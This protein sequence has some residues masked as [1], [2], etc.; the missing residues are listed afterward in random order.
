MNEHAGRD[1]A[2]QDGAF[3]LVEPHRHGVETSEQAEQPRGGG[4][5][6]GDGDAPRD[7]AWHTRDH[8]RTD[9]EPGGPAGA[10]QGVFAA[11]PRVRRDGDFREVELA[12]FSPDV[13]RLDIVECRPIAIDHRRKDERVVRAG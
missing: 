2:T 9:A 4:P 13:E 3:D 6:A 1:V 12:P 11:N 7:G 5:I 8:Q 10:Q